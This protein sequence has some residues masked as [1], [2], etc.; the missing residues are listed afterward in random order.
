MCKTAQDSPIYLRQFVQVNRGRII[1][2]DPERRF[3][4]SW[5]CSRWF[6]PPCKK[7]RSFV[8][9]ASSRA[10]MALSHLDSWLC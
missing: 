4:R 3:G 5:T 1:K 7:F 2:T 6:S 8:S 10:R 9:T